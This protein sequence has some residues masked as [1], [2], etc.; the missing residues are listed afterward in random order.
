KTQSF[1]HAPLD[2]S[3]NA[4]RLVEVHPYRADQRIRCTIRHTTTAA[5]YTC[6]SYVWGPQEPTRFVTVNG[7][8]CE[9]RENLW[10]FLHAASSRAVRA[11]WIDALCID[12]SHVLER[13]HQ[14]Q[15]MGA[16]YSNAQQV[17]TWI[18]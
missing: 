17:I 16:I 14:V 11:V 2:L 7:A 15:Q 8:L 13:N 6:L 3:S 12:Q 9:V 4:I 5:I 10:Q 18:G 1:K